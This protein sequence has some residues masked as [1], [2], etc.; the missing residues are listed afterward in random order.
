MPA[1]ADAAGARRLP[2]P[3]PMW[4]GRSDESLHRVVMAY[5]GVQFRGDE[6]RPDAL[7]AMRE[8][9]AGFDLENGPCTTT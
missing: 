8:I 1:D 3:F 9:V 4:V 5:F 2:A 7:A 6:Q